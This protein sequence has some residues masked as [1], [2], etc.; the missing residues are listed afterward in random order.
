MVGVVEL[1]S[2]ILQVLVFFGA[3]F[4]LLLVHFMW[5]CGV[6]WAPLFE[7]V[8]VRVLCKKPM[9]VSLSCHLVEILQIYT[10]LP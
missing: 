2:E 7:L 10:T 5:Y 3:F 6:L 4:W 1:C 8:L 9:I